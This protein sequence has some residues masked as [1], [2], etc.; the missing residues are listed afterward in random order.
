MIEDASMGAT[1]SKAYDIDSIMHYDSQQGSRPECHEDPADCP[2]AK[3]VEGS[4]KQ[5]EEI[6]EEKPHYPEYKITSL[7][8]EAIKILYPWK[9]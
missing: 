6:I 3:W 2:L 4:D 9:K 5:K 8:A 1:H 7:D